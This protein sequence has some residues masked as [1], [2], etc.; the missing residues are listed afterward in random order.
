MRSL[1]HRTRGYILEQSLLTLYLSA[2]LVPVL[3]IC[4]SVMVRASDPPDTFQ[5]E[6]ALAQIR[7]ILNVS[8]DI[9]IEGDTLLLNY[10]DRPCSISLVN[11]NLVM[12]PGTMI[13]LTKLEEESFSESEGCILLFWKRKQADVTERTIGHV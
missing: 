3:L 5:D 11:G 12:K 2:L 4:C 9:R 10:H 1:H 6:I 7:H 8:D 13:L